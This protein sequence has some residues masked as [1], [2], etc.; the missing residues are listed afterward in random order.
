MGIAD[1]AVVQTDSCDLFNGNFVGIS[2]CTVGA[3]KVLRI[4]RCCKKGKGK[5]NFFHDTEVMVITTIYVSI[6]NKRNHFLFI[7]YKVLV[8]GRLV[9]AK[10]W[11]MKK[12]FFFKES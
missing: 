5:G 1:A 12:V 8:D 7:N 3:W 4:Q 10:A 6:L 9:E 11:Y 2:N